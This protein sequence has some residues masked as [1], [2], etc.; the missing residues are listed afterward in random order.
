[1]QGFCRHKTNICGGTIEKIPQEPVPEGQGAATVTT[2][3]QTVL[4]SLCCRQL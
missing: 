4:I 1:M 3:V 2:L